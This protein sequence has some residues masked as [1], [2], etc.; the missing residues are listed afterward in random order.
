MPFVISFKSVDA[1]GV[2]G[3]DIWEIET[4]TSAW[5]EL[6]SLQG[7]APT[8]G[9]VIEGVVILDPRGKTISEAQL[10]T[11]AAAENPGRTSSN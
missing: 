11:L 9:R 10:A 8:D 7:R 3:D 5:R 4:A 1:D 6:Q 2:T